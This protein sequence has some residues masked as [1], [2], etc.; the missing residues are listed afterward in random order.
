MI[1]GPNIPIEELVSLVRYSKLATIK[2]ALDYMPNKKFDKSLV[3]VRFFA[4][5]LFVI[6]N[7][8]RLLFKN[9]LYL[10]LILNYICIVIFLHRFHMLPISVRC[11]S[12]ATTVF[13]ST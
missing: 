2:D 12:V 5:F 9:I 13:R 6:L 1:D 10:Y 4:S 11:I 7:N 8:G 3:Q